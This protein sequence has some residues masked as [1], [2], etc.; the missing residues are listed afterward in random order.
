MRGVGKLLA[1]VVVVT[2]FSTAAA[3]TAPAA[4][5]QVDTGNFVLED[6]WWRSPVL[7][8]RVNLNGAPPGALQ[9][10]NAAAQ[11]WNDVPG[12]QVELR[13]VGP[14]TTAQTVNDGVNTIYWGALNGALGRTGHVIRSSCDPSCTSEPVDFDILISTGAPIRVGAIGTSNFDLETLMLHEFGHAL[15]LNHADA[16]QVMFGIV[17]SGSEIRSLASGDM[18]GVR[19]RYPESNG[20]VN[21]DGVL[22]IVDALAVA[23]FAVDNRQDV[24]RC[25]TAGSLGRTSIFSLM[26]NANDDNE[27]NIADAFL[28]AKCAVGLTTP[29]CSG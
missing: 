27:V 5:A 29:I 15:G 12:A 1:A 8:Y 18:Q 6:F 20:D 10:I 28:V 4:S 3:W 9:A 19:V 16:S 14:T 2:V 26:G 11:T 24:G 25:P 7:E 21:C 23:Q 17:I 22:N 13:Y